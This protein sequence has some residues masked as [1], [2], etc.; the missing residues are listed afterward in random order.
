M[1][2]LADD[3][4]IFRT[5][6]DAQEDLVTSIVPRISD[7]VGRPDGR[8]RMSASYQGLASLYL[9]LSAENRVDH[10]FD[11][12]AVVRPEEAFSL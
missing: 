1:A 5:E 6:Q 7:T 2:S 12:N 4:N 10:R 3:D 11:V 9:D 8:M